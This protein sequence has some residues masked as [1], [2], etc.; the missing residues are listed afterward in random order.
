M[1]LQNCAKTVTSNWQGQM[2]RVNTKRIL[3]YSQGD[4]LSLACDV[5][6]YPKFLP[7]VKAVRIWN[8]LDKS[9]DAELMIGY[10]NFRIPFSTHVMIDN[11]NHTIHTQNIEDKKGG[12]LGF[13]SP[14]KSLDCVWSFQEQNNQ[15]QINI[16]INLE[17]RDMIIGALVGANLDRATQKLIDNFTQEA[18][19]RFGENKLLHST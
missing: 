1:I 9:F 7:W 18:N 13:K 14:I 6:N 5:A 3:P 4:L 10:K 15:T 11:E 8:K 19:K 2:H 16:L 12:F 17:F